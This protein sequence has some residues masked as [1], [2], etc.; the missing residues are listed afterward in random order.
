M[1][2]I[3]SIAVTAVGTL[4]VVGALGLSGCQKSGSSG[5]MGGTPAPRPG[6]TPEELRLQAQLKSLSEQVEAIGKQIRAQ[7]DSAGIAHYTAETASEANN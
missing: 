2:I 3:R 6:P 4:L 1:K 5:N 7:E